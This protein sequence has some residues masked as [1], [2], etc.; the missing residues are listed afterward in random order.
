MIF[1]AR[2]IPEGGSLTLQASPTSTQQSPLLYQWDLDADGVFGE[3]GP[4]AL[5]GDEIGPYVRFITSGRGNSFIAA[6][7][8]PLFVHLLFESGGTLQLLEVGYNT[9]VILNAPPKI[10]SVG[11]PYVATGAYATLTA[12]ASDPGGTPVIVQWDL[13]LDGVFGET[14][15]AARNGDEL[16]ATVVYHTAVTDRNRNDLVRVR[17]YDG[18]LLSDIKTASIT[19]PGLLSTHKCPCASFPTGQCAVGLATGS[20]LDISSSDRKSSQQFVSLTSRVSGAQAGAWFR[21]YPLIFNTNTMD[22]FHFCGSYDRRTAVLLLWT[23]V[24]L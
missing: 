1:V 20:A 24:R 5:H 11:G 19:V 4:G 8:W 21:A 13:D 23:I 9:I 10:D 16:G 18:A 6:G 7:S 12:S 22:G 17:A 3:I 2:A 14:G 15:A